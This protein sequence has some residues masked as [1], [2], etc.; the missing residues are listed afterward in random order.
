MLTK[1]SGDYSK[2][3]RT[4]EEQLVHF[5]SDMYSVEQQALAQLVTAP[6]IA[7]DP[8]LAAEFRQHHLETEQ[9]A[10]MVRE[11]L[12][13]YGE[14]PS[15]IKDAVMRL[16]GKGFLLFARAQPET[17]GRLVVHSYSYEAMEWAGYQ[18]LIRFAKHAGDDQTF[19]AAKAIAAQERTMME[20]LEHGF[21]AAE[22]VSHIGVPQDELRGH[23]RKHL[24]EVHAFAD[25]DV[26]LLK[27]ST[28]IAGNAHLAKIYEQQLDT[29]RQHSQ[30][31]EQ[32]LE[33]LGSD[34]STTKD[35]ALTVG[36]L[37]W[38]MFF[39]AQSDTPAKL[40]AFVY[41]VLHL[42]I[43]GYELLKRT[44]NRAG[45]A[46]TRR[47]CEEILT[48]KRTMALRLSGAFDSAVEAT[49]DALQK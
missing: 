26:Q 27:K 35:S 10:E 2:V 41:A 43:G 12:E 23:V 16:G 17:P 25:Q 13:A 21:D 49:L 1:A 29:T 8:K 4:A 40:A 33:T 6:D 34:S 22:R 11:R 46:E 14:S 32:R 28:K 44:A 24:A 37:N 31:V 20:R 5:I 7:G 3:H 47:L 39:Q 36:G 18:M 30:L 45:D 42:E 15:R 9:Q 48:D 19:E 38:G